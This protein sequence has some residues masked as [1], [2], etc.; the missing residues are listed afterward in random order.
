MKI[1]IYKTK[2]GKYYIEGDATYR[3]TKNKEQLFEIEGPEC[4]VAVKKTELQGEVKTFD[5]VE[6]ILRG[7]FDDGAEE[8]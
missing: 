2:S 6:D 8:S 3:H 1:F 5:D 4:P 7:I